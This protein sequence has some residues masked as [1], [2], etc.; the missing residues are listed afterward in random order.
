MTKEE[1]IEMAKECNLIGMRP[2]LDGIY[3]ESLEAF[4]KLVAEHE[5]DA[6]TAHAMT[7]AE[8]AIDV[9]IKLEREACA[10]EA[11]TTFYSVQAAENIRAKG[12]RMTDAQPEQEPVAK[13]H[14]PTIDLGKYAGTYGGYIKE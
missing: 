9:A 11:E 13:K 14:E 4:A 12:T 8:K 1:I 3:F 2:H 6:F 7:S 5:R 10:K